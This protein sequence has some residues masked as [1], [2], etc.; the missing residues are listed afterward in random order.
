MSLLNGSFEPVEEKDIVSW[1]PEYFEKV[2][3]ED[4]TYHYAPS[5]I[6]SKIGRATTTIYRALGSFRLEGMKAGMNTGTW[7]IPKPAL[8]KWLVGSLSV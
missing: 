6:A 7:L 2:F 4:E 1:F 3:P 5:E 8:R